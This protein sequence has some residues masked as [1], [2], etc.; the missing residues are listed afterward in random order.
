M[1]HHKLDVWPEPRE[2]KPMFI[3][4]PWLVD[5]YLYDYGPRERETDKQKDNIRIY[6]PI[7]LNREAILRRLQLIIDQYGE[8]SEKNESNFRSEVDMLIEQVCIYDQIWY[9]RTIG[10]SDK[11]STKQHSI[12]G[13]ALVKEFIKMLEEIPDACAELFPFETI[14]ELKKEFEC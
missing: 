6:V 14:D 7:D 13:I 4:E 5:Q 3:N 2:Q 1:E 11:V 10:E 9:V 12:K 8:A